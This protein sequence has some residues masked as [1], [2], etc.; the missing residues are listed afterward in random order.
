MANTPRLTEYAS[1]SLVSSVRHCCLLLPPAYEHIAYAVRSYVVV[2]RQVA[3]ALS[4]H[5][6]RRCE[7][8]V[9]R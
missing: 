3:L 6:I 7:R 5:V 8:Y 2:A 1:R 9:W 4:R